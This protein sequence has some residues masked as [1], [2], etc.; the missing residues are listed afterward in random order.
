MRT[1][2]YEELIFCD[3]FMFSAVLSRDIELCRRVL[4]VILDRKIS[5]ISYANVEQ[6]MKDTPTSKAVRLDVFLADDEDRSYNIEMQ[7]YDEEDIAARSRYYQ[8]NIDITRLKEGKSYSELGESWVIFICTKDY[9]GRGLCKYSY[10]NICLETGDPLNDRAKRIF[11]NAAGNLEAAT[12]ELKEFL[13]Y[14]HTNKATGELTEQIDEQVRRIKREGIAKM[15]Y[16]PYYLE[17]ERVK[18]ESEQEGEKRGE[19][20]GEKKGIR[21]GIELI[22]GLNAKLIS[23]N[24]LED[25]ARAA[26][27]KEYQERLLSEYFPE[28]RNTK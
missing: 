17:L 11:L 24:R 14:I 4:E 15:E 20:R 28:S 16:I 18:K 7:A 12:K 23:E 5:S 13:S 8:A 2:K 19:K 25:M 27:D 21:V 3:N 26:T 6:Y 22:N 9:F 1:K 10:E